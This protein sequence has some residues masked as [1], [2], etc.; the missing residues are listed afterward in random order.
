MAIA[1]RRMVRMREVIESR[2]TVEF[3]DQRGG[4]LF[5]RPDMASLAT[6]SVNFPNGIYENPPEFVDGLASEMLKND[7]K[8]EIEIFDQTVIGS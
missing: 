1:R 4:M 5:H 3:E 2:Q 7:I 6:G 8:A